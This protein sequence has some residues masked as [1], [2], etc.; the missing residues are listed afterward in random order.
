MASREVFSFHSAAFC[1]KSILL[2]SYVDLVAIMIPPSHSGFK[3]KGPTLPVKYSP[4]LK[5]KQSG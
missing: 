2:D 3:R 1:L 5:Q 4:C